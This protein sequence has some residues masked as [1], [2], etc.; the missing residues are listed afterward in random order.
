MIM[1]KSTLVGLS[2]FVIILVVGLFV[3]NSNNGNGVMK[4]GINED[5]E[6]SRMEG[7]GMRHVQIDATWFEFN[8]NVIRIK[9]GEEVMIMINNLDVDHGINIPAL[10]LRGNSIIAFTAHTK[11]EFDFFCDNFCGEGHRDMVGKLI[12]E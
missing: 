8:P 7:G 6:V 5:T 3:F 11:G 10:G 2:I 4:N 1:E 12:I 9:Q